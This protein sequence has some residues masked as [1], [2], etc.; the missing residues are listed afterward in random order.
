MTQQRVKGSYALISL[1]CPKNLVDSE[2]M[3]GLLRLDGYVLVP[4]PE[5]ADF[6]VINTC[7]FIGDARSESHAVIREMLALKR[8]RRI[9]GVIVTGCLAERDK[10]KL[11]QAYPEIDQLVGVFGRDEIATSVHRLRPA[12]KTPASSSDS[13]PSVK[14]SPLPWGGPAG[15]AATASPLGGLEEQRT[16]FRPAPTRPLPDTA[17]LRITPPHLAYLKIA[18]GCN[19]TCS[20]CSIPHMRGPYAS[21]LIEEVV[22]EAEELAADGARELVLVAQDTSSYGLD[23]YGEPRLAELLRRLDQVDGLAWIRLMYLYPMY[24]TDELL[25]V[26]S[27]GK[28]I[29]PYLDLPLQHIDDEVL[30]RM[31]RQVNRAQTEELLDRLRGRIE[32]LVLRTTLIAGFPGETQGQFEALVDFVRRRRF[33]RLGVFTYS[34]ELDT[35]AASLD[36]ALPEDV[37]AARRDR[38]LAVQ[39]E[40][41]F[42]WNEA[43]V[44]RQMEVI[45]DCQV[46]GEP[47]A[48]LGRTYADAPE[49]DGAVYVTGENL[50]PGQLTP[51]EIVAARGY[52]LIAV[53]VER[54]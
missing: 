40:I 16:L 52:D 1:G 23:L 46:P 30:G 28:R 37:K 11:L 29:L 41:A 15:A 21:K 4:K 6:V 27:S 5:G 53:P 10:E 20:F 26:I 2:R 44:G 39:Q 22:A 35:S 43:Q 38:L 42:A 8:R 18:E 48:F 36:G 51:C 17:R 47:H 34:E 3:A 19:R 32:R 12:A 54:D 50:A 7:G 33:E 25:R 49:V 45:I 14:A 24:I 9:R 31:R 13:P